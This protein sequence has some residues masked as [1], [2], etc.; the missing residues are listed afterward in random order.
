MMKRLILAILVAVAFAGTANAD[1]NETKYVAAFDMSSHIENVCA[2]L[3]LDSRQTKTLDDLSEIF[4]EQIDRVSYYSDNKER[5]ALLT[6]TV[7]E[8]LKTVK[9][10]LTAEQFNKY[11]ASIEKAIHNN[12]LMAYIK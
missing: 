1:N 11:K 3:A 9:K 5:E 12:E 7:E 2:T 6:K 4:C 10:I 8:H